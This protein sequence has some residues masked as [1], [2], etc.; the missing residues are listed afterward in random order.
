[1]LFCDS[2]DH[3]STTQALKK[4]TVFGSGVSIS[5]ANG[6]NG[7]ASMRVGDAT[8][9]RRAVV[10]AATLVAGVGWRTAGF[11]A[12]GTVCAFDDVNTE[13]V[14]VRWTISAKLQMTRN[15]T[16]LATGTTVLS[17]GVFYY[18][19]L[20]STINSATGSY[21]VRINGA[22]EMS[23]SGVNTQA[24]AN[25]SADGVRLGGGNNAAFTDWDDFYICDTTGAQNNTFLGDVRIQ[26]VLPSGAGA[27]TQW[28]PSAAVANYTTVDEAAPNDDTDYVSSGTVGQID[29][30]AMGDLTP[31]AGTIKAVQT[32]HY[33]RK[34]DAGTRTIAPVFHIGVTDYVGAN[35]PNLSTTYTYLPQVFETSPATATAWTITEVNGLELGQKV[36]A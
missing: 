21:E 13:Q 20:K 12:A 4:W 17:A 2:F 29:T 18:I 23:A 10:S 6:R 32:V 9:S 28:T 11:T 22:T 8:S 7:T 25:A 31:T 26:A 5:A 3:Y 24:T 19:E 30:Y 34:D 15:G 1:M 33:A 14:S 27:T 16:V 35:L 36:I